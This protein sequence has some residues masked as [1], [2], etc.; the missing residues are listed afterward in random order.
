L[1]VGHTETKGS[2]IKLMRE[3]QGLTLR[4]LAALAKTSPSYL[5]QVE[6][7]ERVPTQRWLDSVTKAL[8]ENLS[9]A[10]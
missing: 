3:G 1:Y 2:A 5:S 9:G 4:Q 8:I 6:R 10:A 7:G